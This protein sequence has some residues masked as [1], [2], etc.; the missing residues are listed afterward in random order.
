[1]LISKIGIQRFDIQGPKWIGGR[2]NQQT[3]DKQTNKNWKSLQSLSECWTSKTTELMTLAWILKVRVSCLFHV[4]FLSLLM[5][6]WTSF[7]YSEMSWWFWQF[8]NSSLVRRG[9]KNDHRQPSG[10]PN[11]T[12]SPEK[13]AWK[14]KFNHAFRSWSSNQCLESTKKIITGFK[15][16]IKRGRKKALKFCLKSCSCA[17]TPF[18]PVRC[19]SQKAAVL[20]GGPMDSADPGTSRSQLRGDRWMRWIPERGN[21]K[22][23][24]LK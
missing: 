20:L 6:I 5:A 15:F 18:F 21:Y 8:R 11:I 23:I 9:E 1:M 24:T 13:F 16:S 10:Y 3:T 12:C 22:G 14:C 17:A 4:P 7:D 2:P 19:T